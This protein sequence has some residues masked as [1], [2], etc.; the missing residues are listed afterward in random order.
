MK[1]SIATRIPTP[2][3][4]GP[5]NPK[6]YEVVPANGQTW[7]L[8]FLLLCSQK[9]DIGWMVTQFVH[10]IKLYTS[11]KHQHRSPRDRWN[12][13]C[14]YMHVRNSSS[15]SPLKSH[16]F[17]SNITN[18]KSTLYQRRSNLYRTPAVANAYIPTAVRPSTGLNNEL[19]TPMT[20]P[21]AEVSWATLASPP[22][23]KPA[24]LYTKA[25]RGLNRGRTSPRTVA[26]SGAINVMASVKDSSA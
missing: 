10:I 3:G 16:H 22:G 21:A 19:A 8:T 13:H 20:A 15:H 12:W 4:E 24:M 7:F 9:T 11:C 6:A 5:L 14:A 1:T 2:T 17:K 25:V 23:T 18:Y 26:I